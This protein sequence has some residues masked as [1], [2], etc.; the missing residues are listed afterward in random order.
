MEASSSKVFIIEFYYGEHSCFSIA[1]NINLA[2]MKLWLDEAMACA[3]E[4][5]HCA[6]ACIGHIV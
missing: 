6:K 1:K 3:V 4:S 2:L 5:E